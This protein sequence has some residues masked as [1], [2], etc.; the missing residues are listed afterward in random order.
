MSRNFDVLITGYYGFG[1]LGDELLLDAAVQ[2][3]REAGVPREKIA[4]LS[5]DPDGT[6]KRLGLRAFDRW[7]LKEV[8]HASKKSRSL[9]LGG[10]GL[11]QDATSV[12]SSLYYWGTVRIARFFGARPW[13][14]GQSVGPFSSAIA[15]RL[16]KN[17]FK[18]CAFRGVRDSRSLELLETWGIKAF[19]SPDLV[20]GLEF[21]RGKDEG[22]NELLFNVRPWKDD[23]PERSA[24]AA[25]RHA[26]EKGLN[27]RGV[28]LSDEDITE[29][30]KLCA[31]KIINL[32]EITLVK[33]KKD[34]ENIQ[35]SAVC[36][37]GMRLH[38][39]IL[40]SLYGIPVGG[41]AYDAKV[42]SLCAEM[43]IPVFGEE[44]QSGLFSVPKGPAYFE[45]ARTELA[46]TFSKGL[47]VTL[48]D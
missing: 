45:A 41:V 27:V 28:A 20:L 47:E 43:G 25:Q 2:Y 36:A 7:K 18:L 26:E 35:Y 44:P 10:G 21:K 38:F 15:S 4:V 33:Q 14:V 31:K 16:A 29:L 19:Q 46:E 42:N 11:F 32:H 1:N 3:L 40:S 34:F 12:R 24:A 48:G 8:A 39:I 23:L 37:M 9:L 30:D 13:A 6:S 17:A 22:A 5:A